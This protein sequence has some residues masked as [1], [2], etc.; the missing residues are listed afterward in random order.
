MASNIELI[1]ILRERTGAGMMDCKHALDETNNDVEKSIDWLR[2]KG[3]AKAA[4]KQSR[5]AAEG[6]TNVKYCEKCSKAA[7]LE[8]NCETD[9]VAKADAFKEL[10]ENCTK[11]IMHENP[12]SVEEINELTKTYFEEA[13]LK[14]GEK[15][16]FRRFAVVD[17]KP[18][19]GVGTYIHMGGKISVL[20]V[21]AKKNE[22][23][24]KGIAMTIAANAPSFVSYA[25][26]PADVVEHETQ[27]QNELAKNDE[28]LLKKPAPVLAKIMEGKVNKA[29]AEL[30]LLKQEYV[31]DPSK[32]IEQVLKENGNEVLSFIRYQ[33]GEGLEKRQDDFA[34]E[35]AKQAA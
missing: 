20:V 22:E 33:V 12:K 21:L 6:L 8:I 27:V 1:K 17:V 10:T 26:I 29:L 2:E 34:A 13:S 35:V 3:I 19:N 18:E 28:S 24:A 4:K 25:D 11:T 5:I 14:L 30:V 32:T 16:S 15:L 9:F 31:L 23:L 7:I